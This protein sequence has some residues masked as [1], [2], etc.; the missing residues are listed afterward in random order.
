MAKKKSYGRLAKYVNTPE[1]MAVFPHHYGI[2][3]EVQLEYRY[4]EN[5]FPKESGDPVIPVVAILEGG[6][7]FP[8]DPL[9]VD[10]LNYFNLSPTQVSPNIFRLVM[11]VMELNRRLGLELTTYDIVATYTLYS[12]KHEA[13]SLRPRHT[14]RTLVNGLL[15]T[16]KDMSDDYL[17]AS[18]SWHYPN[19]KCPT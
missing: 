4:W 9:L 8:M 19:Q 1:V 6:F 17:L 5:I 11:G 10:F 12:T 14:E 16:N 18:G 7:H 2:P 15:D 13:Y 3:D